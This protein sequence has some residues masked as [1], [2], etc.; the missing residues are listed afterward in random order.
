MHRFFGLGFLVLAGTACI[1]TGGDSVDAS[2]AENVIGTAAPLAHAG[3]LAMAIL[4]GSPTS[5]A[6]VVAGCST[7]PCAI[8]VGVRRRSATRAAPSP[9]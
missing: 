2:P 3:T 7:P 6:E 4:A 1:D 9:R 5:C 8:E